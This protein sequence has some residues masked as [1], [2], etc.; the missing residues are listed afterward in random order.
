MDRYLFLFAFLQPIDAS[1]LT[2]AHALWVYACTALRVGPANVA[3]S[4]ID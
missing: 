3:R 2:C 4:H 1:L